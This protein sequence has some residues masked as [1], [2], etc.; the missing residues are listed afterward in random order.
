MLEE[1]YRKEQEFFD[2]HLATL[3]PDDGKELHNPARLESKNPHGEQHRSW[4]LDFKVGD[5]I[6][7]KGHRFT[8]AHIGKRSLI[9]RPA[10]D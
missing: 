8:V 2:R 1:Q 4:K 10:R 6:N 3:Q 7:E 5:V 9:L